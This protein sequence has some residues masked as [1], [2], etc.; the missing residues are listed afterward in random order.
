MIKLRSEINKNLCFFKREKENYIIFLNTEYVPIKLSIK[1]VRGRMT[2][3]L[4]YRYRKILSKFDFHS[5]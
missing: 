1:N 2:P 3:H 4:C 5:K